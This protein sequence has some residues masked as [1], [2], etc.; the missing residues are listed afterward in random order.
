M[1]IA[2]TPPHPKDGEDTSRPWLSLY[3]QEVPATLEYPRRPIWWLLDRSAAAYPNRIACRHYGDETSYGELLSRAQQAALLFQSMGVEPGDRVGLLL[4]NTP[5]YLV[6]SYGAWMAGGV[7][8]SINPLSAKQEVSHLVAK[9]K[10]K[11][12]VS[13]DILTALL[14][15]CRHLH[16]LLATTFQTRLRGWKRYGY[17]FLRWKRT[18]GS[19]ALKSAGSF[20]ERLQ[21]Q[22]ARK[23]QPPAIAPE[24][25]A[26]ILSTGGTTADPK[27][28]VLSHGNLMA[29]AWQLTHWTA[30]SFGEESLMAVVPYFHS[31]GLSTCA[32]SGI[33]TAATTTM[34]HRFDP[35][36]VLALLERDRP[37]CFPAVPMMIYELNR[38]LRER[39]KAFS[40]PLVKYCISGGAP[41][42]TDLA[43]EFAERT[44][45]Q[46]V[47]GY[48]LSEASPV[49]HVGPLDGTAI[50]GTIGVP[51]PDTDAII[52]DADHDDD[53]CGH[54]E[55]GEL[56]IRGPQVMSGYLDNPQA[57]RDAIQSGW[58]RTGDLAVRSADGTFRI[59]DRKKD[60]IITSGANVYPGEVEEV[61]R[62]YQ[63]VEDV[64]VV[65]VPDPKRGEIV[66]A[67][68]TLKKTNKF[69]RKKFDEFVAERLAKY[70][71]PRIIEV[72]NGDLPRNFLGKVVRRKLRN[73]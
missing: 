4:P 34:F 44:G 55:V 71:R 14:D 50:R 45:A 52:V 68:L 70:K 8:V 7:V 31:Y 40:A 62:R 73:G 19:S 46:V 25:P 30:Q 11:V 47:E 59:V 49:T 5:E 72:E 56:L 9:T 36:Q 33:A 23:L 60:L 17:S 48:G 22:N 3:P 43:T 54:D 10:C 15:D 32:T 41:L 67:V 6:A 18:S 21:S 26:Y 29:N 53:E 57:T 12:V 64:A 28:V 35:K 39:G 63:E 51:L 16:Q 61:L 38:L 66:K 2:P 65:G 27:A 20:V 24:D 37:T 13:L 58:L 69:S 1:A 42:P